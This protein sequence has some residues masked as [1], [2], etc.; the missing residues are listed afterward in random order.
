ME[1]GMRRGLCNA[2]TD[3]VSLPGAYQPSVTEDE[4][5]LALFAQSMAEMAHGSKLD[6]EIFGWP[7]LN[8]R[9]AGRTSLR[10]INTEEKLR[11]RIQ[12]LI[13]LSQRVRKQTIRL[14]T[15]GLKK[16]GWTDEGAVQ[17]WAHGGPVYRLVSDSLEYN[18]SLLQH[19]IGP[20][21]Y[22]Q[23]EIDHHVDEMS[24]IRA[25]A[26]TRLQVLVQLY[27]YLRDGHAG[28]WQSTSLQTQRNV[29]LYTRDRPL[30]PTVLGSPAQQAAAMKG[31]CVTGVVP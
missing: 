18:M 23:T 2:V 9:A 15:N 13:K 8:W 16:V 25:V 14:M 1:S 6:T 11:K 26:D 5:G 28:S 29:E 22:V 4:S 7:D 17:A 27:C 30:L 3:G 19:L 12:A 31:A 21:S 24:T 10:G 20:W